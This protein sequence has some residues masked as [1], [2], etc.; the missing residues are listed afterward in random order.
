M[1]SANPRGS[2][3]MTANVSPKTVLSVTSFT[4]A[5]T[6][7][8]T[9]RARYALSSSAVSTTVL[10]L[11]PLSSI[12]DLLPNFTASVQKTAQKNSAVCSVPRTPHGTE[13]DV[14]VIFMRPYHP[15]GFSASASPIGRLSDLCDRIAAETALHF[16]ELDGHDLGHALLFHGDAEEAV[17][18]F[19]RG[20][21]VRD[22][23]ELRLFRKLL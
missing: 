15:K 8:R 7:R 6:V 10:F 13:T 17:R 3:G 18:F 14:C 22:D 2:N 1:R 16:G 4:S 19:H 12:P 5:G 20:L 23:D 11:A 9:Q 21:S